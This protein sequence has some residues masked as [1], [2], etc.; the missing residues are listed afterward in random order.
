M[1]PDASEEQVDMILK[2]IDGNNDN[3]VSFHEFYKAFSETMG[4][5][6]ESSAPTPQRQRSTT[7]NTEMTFESKIEPQ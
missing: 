6:A 7:I 3:E 2:R 5:T 4:D 1:S